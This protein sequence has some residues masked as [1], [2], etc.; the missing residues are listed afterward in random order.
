MSRSRLSLIG[1]VLA[2]LSAAYPAG[3]QG[4]PPMI[5]DDPGTPGNAQWEINIAATG[6]RDANGSEGELPLLDINFG[7]GE[8]VQLKYEIPWVVVDKE[9]SDSQSGLG[10]SLVG[11]KWRFYDAGQE[12]GWQISTYPQVEFRNP[13]SS[14]AQRGLTEDAT[15]L[16]LPFQFQVVLDSIGVNFEVGREFPSRGDDTWIGGVVIGLDWHGRLEGIVEL[17]AEASE[18]FSDSALALNLGLRI[19][20]GARGTLLLSVGRDLYDDR[21]EKASIFGYVGWQL[22]F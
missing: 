3:A 13:G 7:V 17:R 14:S 6:R 11:L 1:A 16:I 2:L 4:G 21:E 9:A 12:G 18:S 22:T 20:A 5:T 19:A 10:N 8:H 15:T